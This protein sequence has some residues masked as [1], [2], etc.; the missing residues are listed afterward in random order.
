MLQKK[1]RGEFYIE[2]M[3]RIVETYR[4]KGRGRA[5][6]ITGRPSQA[7]THRY[8]GLIMWCIVATVPVTTRAIVAL[9]VAGMATPTVG[10]GDTLE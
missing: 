3:H 9:R 4:T 8:S 2:H 7:K 1:K 5:L 10:D 6:E